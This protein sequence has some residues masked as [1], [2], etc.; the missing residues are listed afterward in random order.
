MNI[1]KYITAI[2]LGMLLF[3]VLGECAYSTK[4][5]SIYVSHCGEPDPEP[6]TRQIVVRTV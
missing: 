3:F 2:L 5:Y 4:P 6:I 1:F